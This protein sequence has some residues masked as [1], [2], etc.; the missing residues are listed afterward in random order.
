MPLGVLVYKHSQGQP[1]ICRQCQKIGKTTK[2]VVPNGTDMDPTHYEKPEGKK[3]QTALSQDRAAERERRMAKEIQDLKTQLASKASELKPEANA[4]KDLQKLLDAQKALCEAGLEAPES[5]IKRIKDAQ[6]A[7]KAPSN[8]LKVVLGQVKAAENACKQAAS[9]VGRLETNLDT[10]RQKALACE[11]HLLECKQLQEKLLAEQFSTLGWKKEN[12]PGSPEQVKLPSPPE[13]LS[14]QDTQSW[15]E[16]I[17]TFQDQMAAQRSTLENFLNEMVKK[18]KATP[19][20]KQDKESGTTAELPSAPNVP[21][22]SSEDAERKAKIKAM[23]KEALEKRMAQNKAL[24]DKALED[25]R[26]IQSICTE[27]D[28]EISTASKKQKGQD[29]TSVPSSPSK[30]SGPIRAEEDG[31]IKMQE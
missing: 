2:Y 21:A 19:E 16:A 20:E 7:A 9:H 27:Q 15:N 31:D 11:E 26:E 14:N 10:A 17:R 25:A 4:K 18:C 23:A 12:L 28:E 5:L 6:E 1:A 3:P 30:S 24:E 13:G 8:D 29:G 22:S